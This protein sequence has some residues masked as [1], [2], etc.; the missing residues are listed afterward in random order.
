MAFAFEGKPIEVEELVGKVPE[1]GELRGKLRDSYLREPGVGADAAEA[2]ARRTLD[3]L[4]RAAITDFGNA[5]VAGKTGLL[6][7]IL[8]LRS[9]I[10]DFYSAMMDAHGNPPKLDDVKAKFAELRKA[11]KDVST[12]AEDLAAEQKPGD[13][14]QA[15][16][17][18]I[19]D[20][21][22]PTPAPAN[23]K[24]PVSA[25]TARLFKQGFRWVA[26]KGAWV[27]RYKTGHVEYEIGTDGLYKVKS[28][29]KGATTPDAVFS[30][31]DTLDAYKNKP[32]SSR[33]M[34]AHHGAQDALMNELF[35]ANSDRGDLGYRDG[36]APAMWLR[37]S[38]GDSPHGRITHELQNPNESARMKARSF[39]DI[40]D[41]GVQDL[42]AIGAPQ[43]KIDA[44]LDLLDGYFRDRILPRIQDAVRAGKMTSED[45]AS[46]IGG[47]QFGK[48]AP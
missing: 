38:T 6:D 12:P 41:I 37:D 22:K 25:S 13:E 24:V 21:L 17:K 20:E 9:A 39:A 10:H 30:E 42:K 23:A 18:R 2:R 8:V 33:I 35:G 36:D 43:N 47:T 7:Q 46:L 28:F 32:L 29:S 48:V 3:D 26:E 40:R 45:A 16:K 15:E 27:K 19:T 4:V 1:L 11:L 44:Y 31:F 14:L 34:Q 5:F